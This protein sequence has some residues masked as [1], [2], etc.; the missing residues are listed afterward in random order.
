MRDLVPDRGYLSYLIG[1]LIFQ[2]VY[3]IA[4]VYFINNYAVNLDQF[5]SV[6]LPITSTTIVIVLFIKKIIDTKLG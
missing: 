4:R 5:V 6:I 1:V 2:N 3:T